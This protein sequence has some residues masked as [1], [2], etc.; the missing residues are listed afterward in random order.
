MKLLFTN[1][2]SGNR[3]SRIQI[4]W[5]ILLLSCFT[6]LPSCSFSQSLTALIQSGQNY[7]RKGQYVDALEQLNFAI[8]K[9]PASSELYFLRG[10][11]KFSLDD[12]IGAEEDYNRSIGFS[13]FQAE[14]FVN[15][16]IVR[17]E[18]LNYNGAFEDLANAKKLDSTNADI[19]FNL[20]RLKLILKKYY[21]SISDCNTA[22]RLGY[23]HES[24]Y[25][26]KGSSEWGLK[27]IDNAISDLKKAIEINPS[28]SYSY[29][30]L[31]SIWLEQ[32]H[33][34]SSITCFDQAI[35]L[36]SNNVYALFNRAL[37]RVKV[38]DQSGALEDLNKVIRL[39]PYNSYAYFNRAILFIDRNE[40]TNAIRDFTYVIKLNPKNIVSY[41]YRGMLETDLRDYSSALEDLD[42]TIELSPEYADA[43]YARF[44]VR[45][46][47]KD[48]KR[49][50]EDYKM[51]LELGKKSH[52]NPDSLTTE[53]KDYLQSLVKLSGDFEEMNTANGKFQ[54]Q[55]VSIQLMSLFRFFSDKAP[56]TL[57]RFYDTYPK[58]QY[59]TNL[60]GFT[61]HDELFT[62]SLCRKGIT[63][64]TLLIDSVSNQAD[65]YLKRA[66]YY[67]ALNLYNEAFR[68]LD[69]A[70][71]LDSANVLAYF[72][73]ANARYGLIRL[74]HSLDTTRNQITISKNPA[75]MKSGK[76]DSDSSYNSIIA[77]Y[78]KVL[79]LDT[80]FAFA[81][82]NRAI[83]Y[84]RK[85]EFRKASYD[86]SKAIGCMSDF[87]E[88]Y[89]NRGLISILLNDNLSG[90][91][92]LSR[93]GE[94]GIL[95]AY[96]VI[97]RTCYR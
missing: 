93:A 40:K 49:A 12:Y 77:D 94:L 27:R 66:S 57:L 79:R 5:I 22:I 35:K 42:I 19:Y 39:S 87:A 92:D 75:E 23:E 88:A 31:G 21:A 54:N 80:G 65:L 34:D 76:A 60:H 97:K 36:D 8:Q 1:N 52:F 90:C 25:L 64:Q 68:D 9:E 53:K 43:Y 84:S 89:Y 83:A 95:D 51:A 37:A 91:E 61:T 47:L 48:M 20:G 69:S 33:V 3:T 41:Y 58:E 38:P 45:S 6:M 29:V 44:Q 16:A 26:L 85:G 70:L 7:L 11:A 59:H 4:T 55:P 78:T 2:Q 13:P 24:I 32:N 74:M 50:K 15:R 63:R 28:N 30:Q 56:F 71:K 82:Y 17:C 10:Y 72:I 81:W 73:R 46:K 67:S 86:F 96:R 62:D 14:V 18:R